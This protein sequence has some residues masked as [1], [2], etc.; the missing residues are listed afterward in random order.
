MCSNDYERMMAE[1]QTMEI[2]K[3]VAETRIEQLKKYRDLETCRA[4][5]VKLLILQKRFGLTGDF[6]EI[7]IIADVSF[8][9][10]T[11]NKLL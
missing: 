1:L 8:Y 6:R 11:N 2:P 3:P 5:A 10:Q 4:G 9:V 7:H